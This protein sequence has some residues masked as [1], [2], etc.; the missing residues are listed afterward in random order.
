MNMVNP[1]VAAWHV[2]GALALEIAVVVMV[3]ACLQRWTKSALW[4]RT[5]W[6]VC[7]LGLAMLVAFE[8]T[9]VAGR[10]TPRVEG[11]MQMKPGFSQSAVTPLVEQKSLPTMAGEPTFVVAERPDDGSRGLQPTMSQKDELRRGATLESPMESGW[12]VN[13]RSATNNS[14]DHSRGLNPTATFKSSLRE[15]G[16]DDTRYPPKSA[17]NQQL[18]ASLPQSIDGELFQADNSPYF[19]L[20]LAWMIGASAFAVRILLAR[21][22]F[23]VFQ[24]RCRRV[25]DASLAEYVETLARQ[26]KLGRPVCLIESPRLNGPIVFGIFRPTI[27][28][29]VGF[30][31]SFETVQQ[32]VILAHELAHVA[33]RDPVWHLLA[34]LVSAAVWW[35]PLV[36]WSRHRLHTAMEAA[37][38][39]GSLVI[40]NGPAVLAECLVKLGGR[41][42]QPRSLA[43][44][45][46]EGNGFRSGLGRR[47]ERLVSLDGRTRKS[48]GRV[49][50][51][52]A[53]TFGPAALAIVAILCTAWAH[54]QTFKKGETM[55]ALPQTWKQIVAAFALMANVSADNNA[56]EAPKVSAREKVALE[57]AEFNPATGLPSGVDPQLAGRYGLGVAGNPAATKKTEGPLSADKRQ[58]Q[59]KLHQ[60]ILDEV[61]YDGLPLSEVLKDLSHESRKRDPEKRG[62]NFLISHAPDK[63]ATVASIDPVTGQPLPAS[64]TVDMNN[65]NIRIN[66]PLRNVRLKD[67]LDLLAKVADRPIHYS[68]ENYGVVFAA[69]ATAIGGA[70]QQLIQETAP[71]Y[72]QMD[73]KLMERYGGLIRPGMGN[74]A[75]PAALPVVPPPRQS[76]L[77]TIILKEVVYDGIPLA[78]VLKDLR[79]ES[80]KLDPEKQGINFVINPNQPP[81]FSDVDP[82]TGQ[83]IQSPSPEPV[84]NTTV[85]FNLPLRNVR[86]IDVLDAITKV[87]SRPLAYSVENYGVVF[88]VVSPDTASAQ[89]IYARYGAGPYGSSRYGAQ[90]SPQQSVSLEV[91]TFRVDTNTFLKGLENAFGIVVGEPSDTT[92][93]GKLSRIDEIKLRQAEE[94]FRHAKQK[95]IGDENRA[96]YALELLK[97][98]LEEKKA[99]RGK[100]NPASTIQQAL[101]KLLSQLGVN[102]DDSN[103]AVFFNDLTGILMVRATA[104]DLKV[105]QAAIDTLGG[106]AVAQRLRVVS[107]IGA[108]A[109]TGTLELPPGERMDIIEAIAKSGGLAPTATK[110]KIELTRKGKTT[111]HKFDDL[112]KET[113]PSKKIWLEP[114][115]IIYIGEIMF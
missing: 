71:Y 34:D 17:K 50:A 41:L 114:G 33:A 44:M 55:N 16:G 24:W 67:V 2:V 79:A 115:D 8:L 70:N 69:G 65:V 68:V 105:V 106:T 81:Q 89:P 10:I 26:L 74:A 91:R 75:Q 77:E 92:T 63:S 49:G 47:V 15:E 107:V 98:E 59:T 56:A 29:P 4:Q 62:I 25:V 88:S 109:K 12:H 66:L 9:G 22:L 103:K 73:P 112:R 58:V 19:W 110:S 43:W 72:W 18:E 93:E 40:S 51:G 57:A 86:V 113:D 82:T 102:M 87:A 14:S 23:A 37:A 21:S 100:S 45:G 95:P 32:K 1:W 6:Q 38:D 53:K 96:K 46:I 60:T 76:K 84:D 97:A 27:A 13:R 64:A 80:L 30:A 36:W 111:R 99:G 101:R 35:H 39:E 7:I 5:I 83:P 94:E 90:S 42:A 20:S 108:V 52:L 54:P 31:G 3:A 104:D 61:S 28:L 78:E 48:Q 85:R 11:A